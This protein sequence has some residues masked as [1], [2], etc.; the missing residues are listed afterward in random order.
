MGR[1][2]P[3]AKGMMRECAI[4]GFWYPERDSRIAIQEGKWKCRQCVDSVTEK[5]R[6]NQK[7]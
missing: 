3:Q 1:L 2:P 7:K 5:D 6:A 4:C